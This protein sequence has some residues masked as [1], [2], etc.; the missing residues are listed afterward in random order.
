MA[1]RSSRPVRTMV[2]GVKD[3]GDPVNLARWA[4]R[5]TRR[6]RA[7]KFRLDGAA[8]LAYVGEDKED[9]PLVRVTS[10]GGDT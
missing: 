2:L 9:T 1:R 5:M 6:N 3:G 4:A 8:V 7:V 10:A